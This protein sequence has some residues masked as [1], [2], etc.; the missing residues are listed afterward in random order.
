G[1]DEVRLAL[2]SSTP[3]EFNSGS[4]RGLCRERCTHRCTPRVRHVAAVHRLVQG[5]HEEAL[6]VGGEFLLPSFGWRLCRPVEVLLAQGLQ[7][8]QVPLAQ[9]TILFSNL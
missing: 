9:L 6:P 8:L 5:Q 3:G 7:K 2:I 4:G 1:E